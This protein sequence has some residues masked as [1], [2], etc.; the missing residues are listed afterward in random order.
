MAGF[1]APRSRKAGVAMSQGG[2]WY[3]AVF[4]G[5]AML[6]LVLTP[7]ALR[8]A[9]HRQ[10]LDHPGGHKGHENP[11]PYLG[12]LAM[13]GA[14]SLAV[15]LCAVIRPPVLGRDELVGVLAIALVLSL[16]GLLDDLRG[17]GPWP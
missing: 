4:I 11:V 10:L 8:L 5:S 16:V 13:V 17:L 2:W 7:L 3:A 6:S 9:L 14:F 1:R 15:I 12:G